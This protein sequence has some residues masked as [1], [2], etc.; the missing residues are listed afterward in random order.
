MKIT[1]QPTGINNFH[2]SD[3]INLVISG[4]KTEGHSGPVYRISKGQ[5]RKIENHFCGITDCRCPHGALEQLNG[6]ESEYGIRVG[7][8]A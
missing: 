5:A 1:Y 4:E 2:N 8:C 3:P 6:N 7:Y